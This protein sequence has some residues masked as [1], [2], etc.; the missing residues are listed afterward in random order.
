M[1][2]R[3][4]VAGSVFCRMAATVPQTCPPRRLPRSQTT[5]ESPTSTKKTPRQVR[6]LPRGVGVLSAL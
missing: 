2:R 1:K 5:Q 6:D 4:F 3:T